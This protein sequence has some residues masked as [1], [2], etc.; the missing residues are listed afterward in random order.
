[1]DTA[2]GTPPTVGAWLRWARLSLRIL[3]SGSLGHRI[4]R[5][6]NAKRPGVFDRPGHA[7]CCRIRHGERRVSVAPCVRFISRQRVTFP[8]PGPASGQEPLRVPPIAQLAVACR[9]LARE[10]WPTVPESPRPAGGFAAI[11]STRPTICSA[12]CSAN[13]RFTS[14]TLWR[15][16]MLAPAT[17]RICSSLKARAATAAR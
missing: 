6:S 14:A 8:F 3:R 2:R 7:E 12:G 10:C 4:W 5:S 17:R 13:D 1:M 16:T 11:A 15:P 9:P